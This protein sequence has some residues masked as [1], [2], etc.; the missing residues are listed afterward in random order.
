VSFPEA[1]KLIESATKSLKNAHAPYSEFYVGA[2]V[3]MDNGQVYSGC[4]VENA[5]YGGTVCAERV[6]IFKAISEGAKKIKALV[7][8]TDTEETK[9][10]CGFCRQVMAEFADHKLPVMS[11]NLKGNSNEYTLGE[12]L[13]NSFTS[14]SL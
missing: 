10:P 11:V 7:I 2:A 9:S 8:V 5:S 13:P 4:N 1:A 12:L 6:A 14:E 3:L